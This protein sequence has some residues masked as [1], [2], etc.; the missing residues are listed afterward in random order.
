MKKNNTKNNTNIDIDGCIRTVIANAKDGYAQTY[1]RAYFDYCETKDEKEV[2]VN[3]I[4][5]N[6]STWR[7]ELA[8]ETKAKMK[9]WLLEQRRK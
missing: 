3:Y 2:Q 6:L 9:Q 7:G 8:R 4:L 5:C 1:A